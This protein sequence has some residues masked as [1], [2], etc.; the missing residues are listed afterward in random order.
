M[1][2]NTRL[3][4]SDAWQMFAPTDWASGPHGL[5][6]GLLI[7]TR[8]QQADTTAQWGTTTQEDCDRYWCRF[9]KAELEQCESSVEEVWSAWRRGMIF[10]YFYVWICCKVGENAKKET[11]YNTGIKKWNFVHAESILL[12]YLFKLAA[13]NF[14]TTQKIAKR[15]DSL[16]EIAR[17]ILSCLIDLSHRTLKKHYKSKCYGGHFGKYSK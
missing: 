12:I 1:E 4:P 10:L 15:Y 13:Y 16:L 9:E 5:W 11:C 6:W 2:H 7:L 17:R 8:T 3:H 14:C